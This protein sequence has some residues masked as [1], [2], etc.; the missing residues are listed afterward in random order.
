MGRSGA[1]DVA[2]SG[3][4]G[5]DHASSWLGRSTGSSY[6]RLP[7]SGYGGGGTSTMSYS[8]PPGAGKRLAKP[9]RAV[10][11]RLSRSL[12]SRPSSSCSRAT[13]PS[14]VTH[15]PFTSTRFPPPGGAPPPPP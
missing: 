6:G 7:A 4:Y 10:S 3:A 11:Y 8:Q 2:S 12:T 15:H 14:A 5:N 13:A 9:V 1:G